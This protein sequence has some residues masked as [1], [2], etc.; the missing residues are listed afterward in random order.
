M[1]LAEK[2]AVIGVTIAAIVGGLIVFR[3]T[4]VSGLSAAGETIGTGTGSFFGGIGRGITESFSQ[5]EFPSFDFGGNGDGASELAGETIPFGTEGGTV[6][7]PEDTIV[8]PAGTVESETPPTA[9]DPQLSAIQRFTLMRKGVFESLA[10]IFSF[11]SVESSIETAIEEPNVTPF[12][13]AEDFR[14][15]TEFLL[16][17][18]ENPDI[19]GDEPIAFFDVFGQDLPLSQFALDFFANIDVETPFSRSLPSFTRFEGA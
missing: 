2:A 7:I 15:A 11:S 1:S 6:T 12:S 3:T 8:T 16:S 18:L 5:F 13:A 17:S 19:V 14:Q 4:I 10:E 9:T